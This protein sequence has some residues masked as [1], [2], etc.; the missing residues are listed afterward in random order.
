MASLLQKSISALLVVEKETLMKAWIGIAIAMVLTVSCPAA[1]AVGSP[2]DNMRPY[3]KLAMES[4]AAYEAHEMA[5]AKKKAK[6]LEKAWDKGEKELKKKSP[7]V[8]QQID[9]AMDAFVKPM[10]NKEEPEVFKTGRAYDAFLAKLEL[11]VKG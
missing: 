11:A 6:A 2:D 7:D 3:R 10:M 8:W 1:A 4:M 5:L 9:T